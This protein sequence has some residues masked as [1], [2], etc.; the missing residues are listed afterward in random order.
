MS[1]EY[2]VTFIQFGK[3]ENGRCH[4]A[5]EKINELAKN[6]D[7]MVSISPYTLVGASKPMMNNT[8]HIGM[9]P[10]QL[11]CGFLLVSKHLDP[12]EAE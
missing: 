11:I 9:A 8:G 10:P 6:C 4:Q 3:V 2:H 12:V 1:S 5:E 7:E